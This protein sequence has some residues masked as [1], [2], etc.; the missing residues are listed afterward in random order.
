MNTKAYIKE[1]L[2]LA[3][4]TTLG[5]I[6]TFLIGFTDHIMTASLGRAAIGGIFLSNQIAILLQFIITGIEATVTVLCAKEDAKG[7]NKAFEKTF[8]TALH[9]AFGVSALTTIVCFL[10]PKLVLSLFSSNLEIIDTCAPFLKILALSFIPFSLS[11]IIMT[12]LRAKKL[13]S[14]SL[15]LPLITF[16]INFL[17][18]LLFIGPEGSPFSLGAIGAALATLIS[19]IIELS[20]GAFLLFREMKPNIQNN[21]FKSILISLI[22]P[23]DTLKLFIKAT[24]PILI[25][26]LAWA[27]NNLLTTALLSKSFEGAAV[28]AFGAASA[29]H[30]LAYT[31]MNGT[32][33]SIGVLTSR[34]V[35]EGRLSYGACRTAELSLLAVGLFGSVLIFMLSPPVFSLYRLDGSDLAFALSFSRVFMFSF[36]L[37][38]YSA[39]SLF[40][41]I[42]SSGDV[43]FVSRVDTLLF[44]LLTLPTSLIAYAAGAAPTVLLLVLKLVDLT[45]CPIAYL[46]IKRSFTPRLTNTAVCDKI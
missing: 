13:P 7:K 16:I 43:R 6:F 25:G 45:K 46:Y 36:P 11:R 5:N 4:P 44:L 2:R 34:S 24:L 14:P 15:Y 28:A 33:S 40:G 39:G 35:G 30:N 41:I 26:Q 32:S 37:T 29:V 19:R 10:A 23:K 27:A 9:F 8:M 1:L 22:I 12:A 18:N 17:L 3:L 20:L 42:K 21:S 38:T 31:L